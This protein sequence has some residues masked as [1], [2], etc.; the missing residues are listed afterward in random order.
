ML[1]A[2][3]GYGALRF[4]YLPS[5]FL[6]ISSLLLPPLLLLHLTPLFIPLP[7]SLPSLSRLST[8]LSFSYPSLPLS[9]S[10]LP[11]PYLALTQSSSSS[12]HH[13]H[14][15]SALPHLTPPSQPP[16]P[17][18]TLPPYILTSP[19]PPSISSSL[20]LLTHLPSHPP[21]ISPRLSFPPLLLPSHPP[22]PSPH[23]PPSHPPLPPPHP[24]RSPPL[25]L[26]QLHST[27]HPSPHTLPPPSYPPTLTPPS[28]HSP[29]AHLP[30]HP[31]PPHFHLTPPP[32][33]LPLPAIPLPSPAHSLYNSVGFE[34][35][36]QGPH[37]DQYKRAMALRWTCGLGYVDCV[38]RSVLQFEEWINNGSDVSPNLK[39][40]VYCSAIAAGGEEEWGAAW[41]MYL[42]A[43]LASE[44][45]VLLSALGCTEEVWLLASYDTFA[46]LG[47]LITSATA[48]FNTREERRQL[49]SFIEENQDSLSSVARSVSQALENTN[50]NI[51]WMDS[52][53]D[54]I[55]QWLNDHGYGQ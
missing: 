23:H 4:L 36:L 34:D 2:T 29:L 54:V 53:Y 52:N 35:D 26:S 11:L 28:S 31:R 50:N 18:L 1:S 13:L 21:S 42:S 47:S 5:S 24:P 33:F 20:S 46:S 37:L 16:I 22:S 43:N 7:R 39:S 38:D 44:K 41:D 9:S 51:A 15:P 12:T 27:P 8:S 19:L 6:F 25:I 3:A 32:Y 30:P 10:S 14:L 45:S 17:P 48:K 40:T 55:V 49:E